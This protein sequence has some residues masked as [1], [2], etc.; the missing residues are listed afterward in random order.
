MDVAED[1]GVFHLRFLS[2]KAMEHGGILGG[3]VLKEKDV[4]RFTH[5]F[6]RRKKCQ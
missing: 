2:I 3:F 1:G 5:P 6:E 4:G